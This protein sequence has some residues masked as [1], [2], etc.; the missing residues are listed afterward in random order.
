MCFFDDVEDERMYKLYI[1]IKGFESGVVCF[2]GIF[3][4]FYFCSGNGLGKLKWI[5]Y[6]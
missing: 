2:D 6:F 5:I 3:F 1:I 4:G